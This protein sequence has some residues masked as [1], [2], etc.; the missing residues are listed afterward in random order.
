MTA[1]AN[2]QLKEG[3]RRA[4]AA[5]TRVLRERF[6]VE[7]VILYGSK[8]RGTDDAESD[9]DLLVLTTRRLGWPERAAIT[10]ALFEVEMQHDVVIS[11]LTVPAAEWDHGRYSVLPIYREIRATGVAL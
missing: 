8:A 5:A 3:D 9:I 11:A 2:V 6:P 7:R 10:D 4:I 1:A